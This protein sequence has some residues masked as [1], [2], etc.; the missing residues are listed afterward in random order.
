M[1]EKFNV[2]GNMSDLAAEIEI[3]VQKIKTQILLVAKWHT[4]VF[5][6]GL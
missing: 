2:K 4:L 3:A 1:P 5:Y 6:K